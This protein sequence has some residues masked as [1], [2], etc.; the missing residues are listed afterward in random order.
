MHE[1]F[2]LF[3]ICYYGNLGI[4]TTLEG[5]ELSRLRKNYCYVHSIKFPS[6]EAYKHHIKE[7][8]VG[9]TVTEI[10]KGMWTHAK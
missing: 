3:S 9:M 4:C 1:G 7:M 10:D 2:V 8:H 5:E 6:D